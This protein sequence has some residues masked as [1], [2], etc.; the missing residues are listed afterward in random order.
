MALMVTY[1][2]KLITSPIYWTCPYMDKRGQ[3]FLAGITPKM[4]VIAVTLILSLHL[5]GI[6]QAA[7]DTIVNLERYI[8][9]GVMTHTR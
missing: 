6:F 3:F 5:S 7:L 4:P 8:S 1:S 9:L 2:T